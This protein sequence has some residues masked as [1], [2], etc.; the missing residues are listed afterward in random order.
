MKVVVIGNCAIDRTYLVPHLPS[1]GET[2]LADETFSDIGGKGANQAVA[3]ARAGALVVL[4]SA[5][6]RD[7]EGHRILSHLRREGVETGFVQQRDGISDHSIVLV[8]A[9]TGEN[10]IT[11]SCGMA[12]SLRPE[13][14]AEVVASLTP[15]DTLLMQGN[16]SLQTTAFCLREG[17]RRGAQVVF[18]P[19]P[20][21]YRCDGL[22]PFVDVVVVNEGESRILTGEPD[23]QGAARALVRAGAR[24]AIVTRGSM[25]ALL[26]DGDRERP[27]PVEQVRAVDTTGAGDV[28]CG[29]LAAGLTA[30]LPLDQATAWAVRSATLCVT[31]RGTQTAFPTRMELVSLRPADPLGPL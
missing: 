3:A 16:L 5:V 22:W 20:I 10:C 4:S 17:R 9:A 13:D 25:G 2:V 14:T 29:V 23:P 11:S 1:A 7:E 30:R 24:V 21:S 27:I 31:R 18:N 8:A 6:A 19:S 15:G 12:R 28:L 26:V